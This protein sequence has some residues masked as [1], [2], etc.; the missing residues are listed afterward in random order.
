MDKK[1]YLSRYHNLLEQ[2]E[3]KKRYIDFCEERSYS[4]AGPIYDDM[5]KVPNTSNEAPFVR[6]IFK[7]IEAKEELEVLEKKAVEIKLEIERAINTV[8][9]EELQMLLTYRYIECLT[10]EDIGHK[11]Y[12]SLS[13]IKRKHL[14][15]LDSLIIS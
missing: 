8:K 4:I 6:W 1:E 14:D 10:W 15:A 12:L 2:I 13:S 7:G 5:P 9:D 3:K 11:L